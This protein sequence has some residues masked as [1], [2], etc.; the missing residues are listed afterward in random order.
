[1]QKKLL[2]SKRVPV[3]TAVLEKSSEGKS[4]NPAMGWRISATI[5]SVARIGYEPY[6]GL[7]KQRKRSSKFPWLQFQ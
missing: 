6:C 7:P 2:F 3:R 1:M 4:L 5:I